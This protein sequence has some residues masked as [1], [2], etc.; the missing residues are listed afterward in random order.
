M[1]NKDNS[2]MKTIFITG[3]AQGIGLATARHFASQGWYV[4]L[5]DIN[6]DGLNALL[7]SG[8]FPVLVQRIA[9]LLIGLLL[10]V[11]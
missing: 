4:G 5:Y 10:R 2:A 11:P 6:I 1:N 8:D 9:M 7:E 3:A